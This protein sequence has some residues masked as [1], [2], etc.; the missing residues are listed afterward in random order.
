MDDDDDDDDSDECVVTRP[1]DLGML[2]EQVRQE[3]DAFREKYM[4]TV[5]DELKTLGAPR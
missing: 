4:K 1:E 3:E 2:P 5:A